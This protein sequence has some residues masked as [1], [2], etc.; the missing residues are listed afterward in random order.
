MAILSK[1]RSKGIFLIVIIA[2]ALFAFIFSGVLTN[3][4][5]LNGK[6]NTVGFVNGT[7]ITREDFGRKVE[8]QSRALG[9]NGSTLN[10]VNTIWDREVEA[11]VLKEQYDALGIA[12]SDERLQQLIKLRLEG[13]PQF[14]DEQGFFS[15]GKMQEYIASVKGTEAYAN[16]VA[17]EQGVISDEQRSIYTNLVKAG[18]GATLKDGEVAY[19]LDGNTVDIQF[20]QVPYSTIADD[21]VSVSKEDIAEYV[22]NHKSQFETEATRSIR[23][24]KF[25]EKPTLEDENEVK[26]GLTRLITEDVNL[27]TGE[28][29]GDQGLSEIPESEIA[30]FVN[31]NSDTQYQD[32]WM[33]QASLKQAQRDTL[34]SMEVGAV[35]GPYKRNNFMFL[36]KVVAAKMLP[37]SSS[38][39][40]IL[41]STQ[42]PDAL[43]KAAAKKLADSLEQVVK[44]T[45]SKFVEL[46]AQFS[47]DP[48]SKDKGGVYELFPQGQMV[49]PFNDFSFEKEVGAVGTV[50][51][52]Y[53]YHVIEVLDQTA[54]NKALKVATITKELVPSEKTIGE[55]YSTTQT[56]EIAAREGDF[57]AVA[58]EQG[59][60]ALPVNSIK[61]LNE[62]LPGLGAQ[63][64]IV[65]WTF[66][67]ETKVGDV[68]RFQI[69]DGYV[70]AQVTKRTKE[71]L[72]S[73]EDASAQVTPIVRNKKKAALIKSRI[74][75]TDLNEV[76]SN[77]G[78]TVKTA[79]ALNMAT[80]TI[81]GAGKEPKVVGA[82]FGLKEGQT[83]Q[84]IEGDRGVYL[85]KVTKVNEAPSL[86]NYA[87]FAAQQATTARSAVRTKVVN[88]LKKSADVEDNRATFY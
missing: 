79:S 46:A 67:E 70:V 25:E 77:Q 45:P 53:G 17:F 42:G 87:T 50:E 57:A 7:E 18:L 19:K 4:D 52:N 12:V 37:D 10:A 84:L 61:P 6:Q 51:T 23:Y 8:Q 21:D 35:Y 41:I 2:L 62:L 81:A 63:R 1:I 86:E 75:S 56:F 24:V 72:M 66:E 76:A 48:G 9:P 5:S 58:K 47:S 43:P 60:T 13:N 68:K 38:V 33:S 16:W 78:Q 44:R 11:A 36:D 26:A 14:Q 71:G 3:S 69:N 28:V 85:V 40:H 73:S 15:P 49:A 59:Y 88:A 65:Q 39:R 64:D 20:V 32:R 82:A 27:D 31:E 80:P 34:L 30:D 74:N 83:S 22:N 55:V 54:K 29:F